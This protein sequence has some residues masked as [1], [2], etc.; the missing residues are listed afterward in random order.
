MRS[1]VYVIDGHRVELVQSTTGDEWVCDCSAYETRTSAVG[2]RCVHVWDAWFFSFTERL[3]R[4]E[5]VSAPPS[6]Q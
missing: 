4:A 3:L 5:G 6:V 2:P 1:V